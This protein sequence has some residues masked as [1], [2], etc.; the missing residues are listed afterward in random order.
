[1]ELK[2]GMVLACLV[3]ISLAGGPVAGHELGETIVQIG[4]EESSGSRV[5]SEPANAPEGFEKEP[6]P[7]QTMKGLDQALDGFEEPIE[8]TEAQEDTTGLKLPEWLKLS[9]S[10]GIS[11]SVN[12]RS[13]RAPPYESNLKG[14]SELRTYGDLQADLRLSSSWRARVAGSAFYD[15]V[16]RIRGRNNFTREVLNEYEKEVELGEAY[17]QGSLQPWLDLK[18]GRQIVVWG[19]SDNIR[20]TDVLNPLDN[21]RPGRTDLDF[22]RLPVVMT[23]IDGYFGD[24]NLSGLVVH[25]IRFDKDPVYGSDF[26]PFDFK[27]PPEEEPHRSFENQEVGV[28]LNG[29]FTGWDLSLYGAYVFNDRTHIEFG[30]GGFLDLRLEH[31]RLR[32]G[33]A[34]AEVALGDWLFKAE[35]A[36]LFGFE[37]FALPGERKSRMDALLGV[38]YAGFSETS[39][40]LEAAN[41]HWMDFDEKLRGGPEDA[42]EDSFEWALRITRSFLH[43]RLSLTVLAYVFGAKG[44]DGAFQRIQGTYD[45]TDEISS[46]VG[47]LLYQGGDR[48]L[49]ESFKKNDRVFMEL[50]YHF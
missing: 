47:V 29:I 18:V 27:L 20:I 41:R 35:A 3:W 48:E 22:L 43:D 8:S 42:Q 24:W 45:W 33:G 30:E 38:E 31:S 4:N 15:W 26:F 50:E 36:Y 17:I 7:D 11:S 5:D 16:Y 12:V 1:V 34:A 39:V 6:S 10:L 28:A 40:T 2:T 37:F 23:K 32:M 46:T 19:K 21:R 9:G 25:E 44:Q 13:H 14:L 49:L